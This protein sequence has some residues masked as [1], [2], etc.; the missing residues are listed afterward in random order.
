MSTSLES[1]CRKLIKKWRNRSA[2]QRRR[3]MCA[4]GG[5]TDECVNELL[6]LLPKAMKKG[7]PDETRP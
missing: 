5:A 6:A 2:Q 7:E 1:A 3:G 4:W